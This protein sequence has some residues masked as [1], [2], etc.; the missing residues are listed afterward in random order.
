MYIYT[1]IHVYREAEE[2]HENGSFAL[3]R[4]SVTKLAVVLRSTLSSF[5]EESEREDWIC[6]YVVRNPES[7]S[8]MHPSIPF[9]D[10]DDRSAGLP[11]FLTRVRFTFLHRSRR[12][13]IRGNEFRDVT[14]FY[15][16]YY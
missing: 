7:S 6:I 4:A 2:T 14:I 3:P 9:D 12:A 1:H 11:V 16:Y 15:Y 8:S 13:R 5:V 10:D